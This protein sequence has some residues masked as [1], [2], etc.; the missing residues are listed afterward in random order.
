VHE[1]TTL[2]HVTTPNIHRF[3]TNSAPFATMNKNAASE[4][5]CFRM[6]VFLIS[7]TPIVTDR[8]TGVNDHN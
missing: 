6:S 4:Y 5:S 3:C 2:L 8:P 7:A 1:T